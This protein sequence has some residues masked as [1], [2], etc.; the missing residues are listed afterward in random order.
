[1]KRWIPV[2]LLL[3]VLFSGCI[4]N[5]YPDYGKLEL[6]DLKFYTNLTTA[7]DAANITGEP[8]FIYFLSDVCGWCKKFEDESFTN[9]SIVRTLSDNFTIVSIDVYKQKNITR[10]YGVRG[11]PHELFLYSNGTE[12]KRLPGYVDNQTFLNTINEIANLTI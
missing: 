8:V 1:M 6:K 4:E 9:K 10:F 5:I 11:T 7:L 3:S 2:L 12:I